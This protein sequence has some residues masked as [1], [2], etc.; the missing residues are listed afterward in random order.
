MR[1]SSFQVVAESAREK[2]QQGSSGGAKVVLYEKGEYLAVRCDGDDFYVCK[3]LQNVYKSSKRI[4]IHWLNN[5]NQTSKNHYVLDFADSIERETILTNLTMQKAGSRMQLPDE[6]KTRT[7]NI[8]NRAIKVQNGELPPPDPKNVTADGL[9]VSLVTETDPVTEEESPV[10]EK[11][12]S[13]PKKRGRK[14]GRRKSTKSRDDSPSEDD[15][16]F[17]EV[18]PAKVPKIKEP[19][20][21]PQ[22]VIYLKGDFLAVQNASDGFYVCKVASNIHQA[23]KTAQ[24]QWLNAEPK[25]PNMFVLDYC[26]T[27]QTESILTKVS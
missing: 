26:D 11:P 9:D 16:D 24:I 20:P 15:D 19:K 18:L 25:F 1:I 10:K 6:E 13:K 5:E 12:G 2:Q 4:K 8:L 3:A 14:S 23:A 21:V 7:M 17:E 22:G 27:I